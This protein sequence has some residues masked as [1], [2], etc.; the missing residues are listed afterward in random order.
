MAQQQPG[1]ARQ[2]Q[3]PRTQARPPRG[4]QPQQPGPQVN[5]TG[6][7]PPQ[8][9]MTP[10]E[11]ERLCQAVGEGVAKAAEAV[12][13]GLGAAGTAVGAA[14]GDAAGNLR[15]EHEARQ[16][17]AQQAWSAPGAQPA[18]PPQPGRTRS[19]AITPAQ[20]AR[21]LAKGRFRSAAP[22]QVSGAIMAGTGGVLTFTFG[23][24]AVI[25]AIGLATGAAPVDA[26][27]AGQAAAYST[28]AAGASLAVLAV[29]AGLSAWLLSA[30]VRR[31]GL[32]GRLRTFRRIMGEREVASL[33]ELATQSG[34]SRK[35][36]LASAQALVRK[37]LLPAG[38]IDDEQTC[39]MVT[40][41]CYALY[42]ESQRAY[43]RRRREAAAAEAARARARGDQRPAALT[44]EARALLDEGAAYL[45]RLR[46]LDVAIDDAAVSAKVVAIEQVVA[47][48]LD[49]VREEPSVVGGLDRLMGYYLP[50]TVKL[51]VAYDA[52]EDQP[53]QGDT[54]TSSRREIEQT[55]DVLRA[56]YEKLL[57]ET[58]QDLS[59]DVSSDISVL[60]AMLAQE[61]LT[62]SP[63]KKD[64]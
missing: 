34:L 17:A 58:Y 21:S 23:L 46:D 12:G 42:R 28:A 39:L 49:R 2:P 57:D 24:A 19:R 7:V 61:G 35:K 62:E 26:V 16:A 37:G 32:A 27:V 40:D 48:I 43:Q 64:A 10:E 50:T 1:A 52:L 30:G 25:E 11:F 22:L 15:R 55:L 6:Q 36:V 38:H 4:A 56:A 60:H 54:I 33:D 41:E 14:L 59:L 45:Q 18:V 20:P 13:R 31:L 5:Q 29:L 9:G 44:D 8:G 53:V 51:L 63:F 3:T 47:R